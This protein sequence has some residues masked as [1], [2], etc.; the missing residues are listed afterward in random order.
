[1]KTLKHFLF[2]LVILS[3][4]IAQLDAMK[5]QLEDPE[6]AQAYKK[7]N[8]GQR[9]THPVINPDLVFGPNDPDYYA[10][11]AQE[12]NNLDAIITSNIGNR[13]EVDFSKDYNVLETASMSY[14][15]FAAIIGVAENCTRS[16]LLTRIYS[17]RK[18]AP[19]TYALLAT[20]IHTICNR[21]KLDASTIKPAI[22]LIPVSGDFNANADPKTKII[23]FP[24]NF[25]KLMVWHEGSKQYHKTEG[26]FDAIIAHELAHVFHQHSLL[27]G[28]MENELEADRTGALSLQFPENMKAVNI[29]GLASALFYSTYS[30]CNLHLL[31]EDAFFITCVISSSLIKRYPSLGALGNCTTDGHMGYNIHKALEI[32]KKTEYPQLY[33]RDAAHRKQLDQQDRQIICSLIYDELLLCC[34]QCIQTGPLP[35]TVT[36]L[37]MYSLWE[38]S[39]PGP[40]RRNAAI[41]ALIQ[42]KEIKES[43]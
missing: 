2:S 27:F 32:I 6:Y 11:I 17:P 19:I 18:I 14:K 24:V 16:N 4:G 8:T 40:Q 43:L 36:S 37:D 1:M 42:E 25:I 38:G 34:M 28:G 10:I 26:L 15:C 30:K 9:E 23:S 20:K 22:R 3:M 35:E 12:L 7:Q 41:Q 29:L 21:M 33:P 31:S 5:R 13:V 39:Y